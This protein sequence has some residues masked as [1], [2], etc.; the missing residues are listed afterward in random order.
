MIVPIGA[1]HAVPWS[2]L[3]TCAGRPV[4][5]APSATVWLRAAGRI[6]PAG[7]PVLVAGPA[8]ARRRT[9]VRQLGAAL[10]GA[11]RSPAATPPPT[12]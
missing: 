4:T 2:G 6:V 11:R 3:P 1:L 12:R 10:P 9:E 7:P 5:V 8:A